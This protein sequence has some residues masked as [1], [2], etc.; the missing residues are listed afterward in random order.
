MGRSLENRRNVLSPSEDELPRQSPEAY[1]HDAKD[2]TKG[3][4][5]FTGVYRGAEQGYQGPAEFCA[6]RMVCIHSHQC[7]LTQPIADATY[8]N[9]VFDL[10]QFDIV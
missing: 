3:Q 4:E 8:A 5:E 10:C 7:H 9:I 6:C 2:W 1:Q